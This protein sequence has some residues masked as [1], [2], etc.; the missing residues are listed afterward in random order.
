MT[1]RPIAEVQIPAREVKPGDKVWHNLTA[2][3]VK[4]THGLA[5]GVVLVFDDD[6]PPVCLVSTDFV[7]IGHSVARKD[8][9]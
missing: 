3:E 5:F 2:R 7:T 8:T 9:L 1:H 6:G 4:A